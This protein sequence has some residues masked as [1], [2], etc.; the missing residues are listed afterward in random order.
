[1]KEKGT[2]PIFTN[3]YNATVRRISEGEDV[4]IVDGPDDICAPLLSDSEP[5]CWRDGVAKGDELAAA[6]LS[7]ML[8]VRIESGLVLTLDSEIAHPMRT[9]FAADRIRSACRSCVWDRLCSSIAANSYR[10]SHPHAPGPLQ[11]N[12]PRSMPTR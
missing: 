1:M 5:H 9:A 2:T 12:D 4:V 3:S 11:P 7:M 10:D 6:D 8:G